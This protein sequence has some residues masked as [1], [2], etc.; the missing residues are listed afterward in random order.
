MAGA[1]KGAGGNAPACRTAAHEPGPDDLDREQA[2]Q[3]PAPARVVRGR[4]RAIRGRESLPAHQRP[5]HGAGGHSG[6][7]GAGGGRGTANASAMHVQEQQPPSLG[8][9]PSVCPSAPNRRQPPAHEA[10]T[11]SSAGCSS[12]SIRGAAGQ[13]AT[14]KRCSPEI[15]GRKCKDCGTTSTARWNGD[16]AEPGTSFCN[17]CYQK[18]W[19]VEARKAL[20]QAVREEWKASQPGERRACCQCSSMKSSKWH[21]NYGGVPGNFFCH[22]CGMAK[23]RAASAAAAARPGDARP[24]EP[25]LEVPASPRASSAPPMREAPLGEGGFAAHELAAPEGTMQWVPEP[26]WPLDRLRPPFA[27]HFPQQ[28]QQPRRLS[29]LVEEPADGGDIKGGS[30]DAIVKVMEERYIDYS[31]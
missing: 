15:E 5:T 11:T 24:E 14:T 21:R 16:R 3:P 23:R 13:P 19:R 4:S 9:S 22:K 25:H 1:P 12:G 17:A 6:A 8:T 27:V 30:E 20:S 18:P 31:P 10:S 28:Q 7:R 2:Q 29:P 26:A